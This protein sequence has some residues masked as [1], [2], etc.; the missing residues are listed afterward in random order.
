MNLVKAIEIGSNNGLKPEGV[1][2]GEYLEAIKLLVEAGKAVKRSRLLWGDRG[3]PTLPGE[4]E[5]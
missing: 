3:V 5:E 1:T 2:W 4:T